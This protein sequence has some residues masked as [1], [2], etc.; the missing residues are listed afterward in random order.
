MSFLEWYLMG[1]VLVGIGV[2]Y[3][4]TNLKE[5][6][7]FIVRIE[8]VIM[9]SLLATFGPLWLI[10]FSWGM[11]KNY[12]SWLS[13]RVLN[14]VK[15]VWKYKLYTNDPH[16]T[17]TDDSDPFADTELGRSTSHRASQQDTIGKD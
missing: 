15:T 12:N 2:G 7:A 10:V 9:L 14:V 16:K 6:D 3:A 8:D 17:E 13:I 4:Y 5:H 11:Y 1:L